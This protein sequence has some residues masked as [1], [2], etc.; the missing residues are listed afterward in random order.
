L[1]EVIEEG[2]KKGIEEGESIVQIEKRIEKMIENDFA[3]SVPR[4]LE[5]IVRTET[6]GAMNFGHICGYE[7]SGVV[8]K[9]EWL[10]TMDERVRDAHAEADGQIVG[11]DEP[12]VVGGEALEYPGDPAGSPEN[13]INCRCT[14]L[15]VLKEEF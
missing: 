10:A 11:M 5:Y 12:F 14:V 2:I 6:L 9:K 4:R 13:V 7:Q 3:L 8:E 15:P 1:I